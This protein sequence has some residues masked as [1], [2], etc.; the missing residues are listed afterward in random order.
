MVKFSLAY[1]VENKLLLRITSQFRDGFE[2]LYSFQK[3][4][5]PLLCNNLS[6]SISFRIHGNCLKSFNKST[7][8][9]ESL[10]IIKK[11]MDLLNMQYCGGKNPATRVLP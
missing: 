10:L 11:S 6:F 2:S 3:A 8:L 5:L 1:L 4:S 7:S 9:P